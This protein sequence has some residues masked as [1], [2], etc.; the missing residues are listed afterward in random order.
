MAAYVDD[1]LSVSD[2]LLE[3]KPTTYYRGVG[4]KAKRVVKQ[5]E[6]QLDSPK[7][8]KVGSIEV[9]KEI[10]IWPLFQGQQKIDE[11]THVSGD[12]YAFF[13]TDIVQ[14]TIMLLKP[15]FQFIPQYQLNGKL[16][17]MLSHKD[18]LI[19]DSKVFTLTPLNTLHHIQTLN[20][21]EPTFAA[22]SLEKNYILTSITHQAKY[23]LYRWQDVG[24]ELIKFI[25]TFRNVNKNTGEKQAIMLKKGNNCIF[26]NC[27]GHIQKLTLD[28]VSSVRPKQDFQ[29]IFKCDKDQ[30]ILIIISTD[31]IIVQ[32]NLR[33]FVVD[34]NTCT[35]IIQHTVSCIGGDLIIQQQMV[36]A[37][38]RDTVK[39]IDVMK[40]GWVCR[41][42]K[43]LESVYKAVRR[44]PGQQV[45]GLSQEGSVKL[46]EVSISLMN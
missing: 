38:E 30:Y 5:Q 7:T 24:Y 33:I 23:Q 22:L 44:L 6:V 12:F 11:I 34:L 19:L 32:T 9:E 21:D 40:S 16:T 46:I 39:F 41:G 8:Q 14:T 25:G 17:Y 43:A 29:N 45:I 35:R 1:V 37:F 4:E 10:K 13:T 26:A 2:V 27:G 31:C 18:R 42:V 20:L 28:L 36:I 15:D 3:K